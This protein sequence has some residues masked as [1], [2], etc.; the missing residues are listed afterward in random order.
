MITIARNKALKRAVLFVMLCLF[1]VQAA[2]DETAAEMSARQT[3]R[4]SQPAKSRE[5]FT[6]IILPDT[7][8]YPYNNPSWRNS[9]LKEV[10]IQQT[11]W[12]AKNKKAENIAFV[13]HMGDIVTTYD[14]STE[15]NNANEAM[16]ILDGAVPYCFTVGNH[17][18][19][20]REGPAHRNTEYYNKTFPYTRY[21]N[22][23]WYGGRMPNDGYD[24]T[25]HFFNAGG[26]DFM[27]ISLEHAPTDKMLAWADGI[28]SSHPD[29][30]V[31][32]ITHGYMEGND[33]RSS[34]YDKYAPTG[35]NTGEE[36]WQKFVKKH[37]NIFFVM[38]GHHANSPTNKG[39][40]ISTGDN[41]NTVYQLLSGEYYDGWLRILRFVPNENKIYV[42][43]YSPWQP[44]DPN[45]Q[46]KQYNFS[47]PGYNADKYHQYELSYDMSTRK[48]ISR[49]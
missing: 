31:I 28:V 40:L 17:D 42:K 35:G 6:I 2:A 41:G 38:C 29:K 43:A 21:E 10:F 39:L 14:S 8:M 34:A 47:L 27:I 9:S 30:R 32:L 46:Y 3:A 25:Y 7:Q 18:M 44:K 22:E 20:M 24:N 12:I 45:E 36:I 49:Q 4:N 26:M 16:S 15:W 48:K 5:H 13:L 11:M 23:P 19:D 33:T 1:A 37:K